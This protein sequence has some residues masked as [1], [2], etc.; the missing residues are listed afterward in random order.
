MKTSKT[1]LHD[2][3]SISPAH[4]KIKIKGTTFEVSL[5]CVISLRQMSFV[6][7]SKTEKTSKNLRG[8]LHD[9]NF[10][11]QNKNYQAVWP[12]WPAWLL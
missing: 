5:L 4:L 8:M 9:D 6:D 12:L 3:H 11:E 10:I 1:M 2:C 7:I